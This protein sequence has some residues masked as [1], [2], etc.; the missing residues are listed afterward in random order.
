MC[1]VCACVRVLGGERRAGEGRGGGE[2]M[3]ERG[4][5]SGGERR[6]REK[7]AHMAHTSNGHGSSCEHHIHFMFF[8]L[9]HSF[10]RGESSQ[11]TPKSAAPPSGKH[12]MLRNKQNQRSEEK[13]AR[14]CNHKRLKQHAL[15][16]ACSAASD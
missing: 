15:R 16:A 2:W 14:S 5:R 6:R 9:F 11:R 7:L 13:T 1:G 12:I 3:G 10:T 8:V 4:E